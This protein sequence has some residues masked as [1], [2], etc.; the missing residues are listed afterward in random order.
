M[1]GL[2]ISRRRAAWK[3]GIRFA[4]TGSAVQPTEPKLKEIFERAV[5]FARANPQSPEVKAAKDEE[6]RRAAKQNKPRPP[7]GRFGQ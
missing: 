4:A 6:R 3:N 2:S 1:A 5:I 7:Q